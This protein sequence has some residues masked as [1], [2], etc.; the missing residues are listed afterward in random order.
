M[1]LCQ[2][3]FAVLVVMPLIALGQLPKISA[4]QAAKK[5]TLPVMLQAWTEVDAQFHPASVD[6]D[7]SAIARCTRAQGVRLAP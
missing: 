3:W 7:G 5:Q 2:L 6:F 4:G 1:M